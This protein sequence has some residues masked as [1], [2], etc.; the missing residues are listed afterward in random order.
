MIGPG[1]DKNER[2][3]HYDITDIEYQILSDE[4]MWAFGLKLLQ[5]SQLCHY[6][7][8]LPPTI[9][10]SCYCFLRHLLDHQARCDSSLEQG[11]ELFGH[12]KILFF[13]EV[14]QNLHEQW[15]MLLLKL[16][17]QVLPSISIAEVGV[18]YSLCWTTDLDYFFHMNNGKYFREM[19]F[20]RWGRK[21][22]QGTILLWFQ[23]RLLFPNRL[24]CLHW[25]QT[26]DVCRSTWGEHQ[27]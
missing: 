3:S 24:F 21:R 7:W 26:K 16:Q 25:G 14:F 27:I 10:S 12:A 4:L 1:S 23:V 17:M 19:D 20:A 22:Q 18:T 8:Y 9:C 5:R 15:S 13:I 6:V 11:G 2:T